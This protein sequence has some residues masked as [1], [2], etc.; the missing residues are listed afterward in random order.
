MESPKKNKPYSEQK[1]PE[2]YIVSEPAVL[3]GKV[4][5][6]SLDLKKRYNYADYLTWFDDKR[7]ELIDGFIRMMS[8]APSTRH[9]KT[10][11]RLVFR[12]ATFMEKRKGNC[13][14]FY[15]PFDVRLPNNKQETA[16][17]K[18]YTVVQ[19]DICLVCD[20]SKIDD[21]GCLGAPDL[22]IEI[23]S[24]GTTRYDA[25]EKYDVYEK[26]SVP[27]YWLVYPIEGE[28]IVHILQKTGKYNHGT[29]YRHD[30]KVPVKAL[31]GLTMDLK[32]LFKQ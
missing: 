30:D 22:V 21:A 31:K 9:A 13:E 2:P 10:S 4:N 17:D 14:L 24:P 3:Y 11:T 32:D 5:T 1:E 7:R 6:L 29:T 19:P 16:D 23:Q 8:P 26:A 20:L 25:V 12:L 15:A 27:E 18:I 28:I